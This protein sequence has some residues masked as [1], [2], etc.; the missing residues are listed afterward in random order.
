VA[1]VVGAQNENIDFYVNGAIQTDKT[2][3]RTVGQT[4][5]EGKPFR[6]GGEGSFFE[7]KID[8]VR[9][10][11]RTLTSAEIADIAGVEPV[12]GDPDVNDDDSVDV[13][14]VQACVNVILNV[15]ENPTII[16]RADVNGD[17][18]VDVLDVQAIVNK[19]LEV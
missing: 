18:N 15:E 14:D 13:L 8:D 3:Q 6:V 7:G 4:V 19:I 1:V 17:T 16:N 10:Y 9:I 11:G 12:V 2:I 5:K